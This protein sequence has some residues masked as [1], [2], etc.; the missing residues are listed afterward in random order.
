MADSSATTK[1]LPM[2]DK[3]NEKKAEEPQQPQL[4]VL[5]EDDEFEEFAVQGKLQRRAFGCTPRSAWLDSNPLSSTKRRMERRRD[6]RRKISRTIRSHWRR[7][8]S[9]S[10]LGR[11]MG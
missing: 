9:F 6:R 1:D 7:R 3:N 10:S 5:E 11:F 2:D 4:G 8:C